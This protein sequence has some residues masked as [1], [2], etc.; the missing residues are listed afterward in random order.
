MKYKDRFKLLKEFVDFSPGNDLQVLDFGGRTGDLLLASNGL[1][2]EENY[3]NIEI[4]KEYC[5]QGRRKFPKAGWV[6]YNK[7]NQTY[8]QEGQTREPFPKIERKIDI[9]CAFNVFQYFSLNEL[10]ETLKYLKDFN[11]NIIIANIYSK[12]CHRTLEYITKK[13][14]DKHG[15]CADIS[16]PKENEQIN[17]FYLLDNHLILANEP[18]LQLSSKNVISSMISF[19]DINFLERELKHQIDDRFNIKKINRDYSYFIVWKRS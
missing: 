17:F 8:N 12:H 3:T 11:P 9:I 7:F 2:R 13:R 4:I 10:I 15:Y 6:F 5:G 19:Y 18:E 16:Q 1:I 14:K